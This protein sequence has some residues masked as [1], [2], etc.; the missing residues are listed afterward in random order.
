M[1]LLSFGNIFWQ[2]AFL[3]PSLP[4]QTSKFE[5]SRNFDFAL[6]K[7]CICTE[8]DVYLGGRYSFILQH[9][10]RVLFVYLF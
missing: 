4:R 6:P 2:P 8:V 3:H 10:E 7:M 9:L 1:A 5:D